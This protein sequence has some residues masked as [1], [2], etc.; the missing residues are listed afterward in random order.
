MDIVKAARSP[1]SGPATLAGLAALCVGLALV[2]P[3]TSPGG[4]PVP[5]SAIPRLTTIAKHVAKGN[6]DAKPAWV[7]V[8]LT[9][10]AKALTSATPG[11]FVPGTGKVRVYL[12]TMQGHFVANGVS[13]PPGAAAPRGSYISVVV[14]ARTFDGMDFGI[15]P[16]PPPVSPASLGPV[17]FLRVGGHAAAK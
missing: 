10:H 7:T 3:G 9:T 15:G 6:G 4:P 16:N 8:V 11:D 14:D 2:G 1:T 5:A 12:I 13:V 17:T